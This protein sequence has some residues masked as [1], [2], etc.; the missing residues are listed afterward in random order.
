MIILGIES[1][2]DETSVAILERKDGYFIVRSHFVASQVKTHAKF[3]GVVPEVAARMHLEVMLPGLNAALKEAKVG[4]KELN[5]IA[6][7]AGPGLMSSLMV[8]V[9]VARTLSWATKTPLV[10]VNHLAGHLYANWLPDAEGNTPEILKAPFPALGLLVSG[11]H[12]ELVLMRGHGKFQLLGETRDDAAGE[13]FDKVA[14]L[15]GLGYPG[16]PVLSKLASTGNPKAYTWPRPMLKS[17]NLEFSFAGLKT[18]VRYHLE[19]HRPK[20][21]DLPDIA[22]SFEQAV[23]DVLVGKTLRALQE[24]KVKALLLAGGVAANSRLRAELSAAVARRFPAIAFLKPNLPYC[25]DNAAMIAAAG[26]FQAK[27]KR[28]TRWDTL[29]A[30]PNWSL[31]QKK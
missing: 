10:A 31:V 2:C 16:G 5:A 26:Y 8:G 23:V 18:A 11:G 29:T 7:T 12:T 24:H 28:F 19:K 4:L 30:D 6:V 17:A 3:G 13:A 14:K 25:T 27:Q 22:A 20:K 21:K 1:S 15:M 9:E